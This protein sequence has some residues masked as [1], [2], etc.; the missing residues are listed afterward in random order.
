MNDSLAMK[1]VECMERIADALE[2]QNVQLDDIRKKEI[3][4][5]RKRAKDYFKD[6][7]E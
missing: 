6:V 3:E 2:A 7:Y 1:L 4:E 5:A